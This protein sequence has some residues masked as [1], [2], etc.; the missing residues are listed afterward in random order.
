ML[1]VL[2]MFCTVFAC[3][4]IVQTVF[5]LVKYTIYTTCYYYVVCESVWNS[6]CS[7]FVY[8]CEFVLATV[9]LADERHSVNALALSPSLMVP[10][11]SL[12]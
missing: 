4:L 6:L 8:V 1:L 5:G 9:S 7:M 11:A 3:T 2:F 10:R 12:C